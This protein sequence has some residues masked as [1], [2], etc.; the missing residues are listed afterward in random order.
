MAEK[1][2]PDNEKE[3]APKPVT[4]GVIVQGISDEMRVAYLDYAMTVI[5]SRALPDVR[6]GL[7][8][9]HRRIL[10]AMH[11]MGLTVSAKTRKSA[12]VVGEVLGKYHPHGDTAVYD[13]MVNM[14]QPF[15]MRYPL[16]IGQGN[17][18]SIDGD[19]AAAMRYTEAK[20]SGIAG[21][22]L[23]DLEK[24]TVNFR[25]NYDNTHKEPIV[26]PAAVPN[27]L[28]NG[29]LGIAVGMATNIPP[30]NFREV[31]DAIIHLIDNPK[32]TVDDLLEFV[33]GPDF[34][35]GCVAYNQKDI[36]H[37]YATGR[38]GVVVRGEA[39]V[40]EN[41]K[42]AVQ[43]IITSIPY[44][45]N[46]A[47][48]ITKIADLVL[49]KKLEGIKGLRDESTTDIRIA[50]DLKGT[51]HPQTVLN[52]IYKHTQLE[53]T[54]HYNMVAL[55]DGV[56]KTLSLKA[57]MESFIMHRQEVVTRRTQF[58]LNKA[59]AREHILLGLKKALDIIDKVIALIRK[60]KDVPTAHDGLMK[61]FKF[62][63]LQATAILEMRLQKLANL[64]RKKI[65]EELAELKRI[66]T[67]LEALLKSKSKM[68]TLI[69]TEL[70]DITARLS[71]ERRTKIMKRGTKNFSVEDVIADDEFALVLT[72]GGYIKRTN[73]SEYRR[74]KRGGVG[75]IDMNTKEEDVVKTFLT[76]NAHADLLFFTDKGKVYRTKMYE[77]PEGKRSTKGKSIM[78]FLQLEQDEHVSSVLPMPKE[79]KKGD[80]LS[81]IMVTRE[82]TVKKSAALHFHDV[83]QSGLIAIKLNGSDRLIA[84]HFLNEGDDVVL[85]TKNGQAIRFK[86][87]DVREMGRTAAGVNGIKL[88][89]EDLVIGAGIVEKGSKSKALFVLSGT[90]YGKKTKISEYKVQKRAGSGIKTAQIT[91]KTK[92]IIGAE[93]IEST[94]G[95]LVAV[96]KKGQVIRTSL[97]EVKLQGRQTQG[98][99]IMKLRTGDSIA[100]M[101]TLIDDDDDSVSEK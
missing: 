61:T 21:G 22:L 60:S 92:E 84:A 10:Y 58:D 18:G 82:G 85:V 8:P 25:P 13:S 63:A 17:F 57:M 74:Q 9:V 20:M 7:K 40:V 97:D 16:V 4:K 45:V 76:A 1:K 93:I 54:F 96:S 32:S 15:T 59:Q 41:E 50:I 72:K 56:P 79:I 49:S 38:G 31:V 39:E 23:S 2:Q 68:M 30:H 53:E 27:L 62:S 36:A 6:D 77:I 12:T 65:E 78:N 87:S 44:R 29:T 75:V 47:N 3:G 89:K 80:G 83:R 88:G 100:S 14:A 91:P 11:K 69:K 19:S 66:I 34:P 5:T 52:Y 81:L 67:E 101:V 98:V 94:G 86:E 37:A 64:E 43:I 99:R 42:G 55:V 33:K 71:D 26:L 35:T 28:L 51:A 90:G 70:L 46:K 24:D 73:P 48:L 95:E